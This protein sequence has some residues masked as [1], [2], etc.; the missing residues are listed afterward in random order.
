MNTLKKILKAILGL[1][2]KAAQAE[3]ASTA[4]KASAELGLAAPWQILLSEIKALFKGD[5]EIEIA[6]T[7]DYA[8][9]IRAAT[10]TKADALAQLLPPSYHFGNVTVAITVIPGNAKGESTGS[11]A[12]DAFAGNAAV[13]DI[14]D[15]SVPGGGRF[16]Y[17]LFKPEIVQF[18]NDDLSSLGLCTTFYAAIAQDTLLEPTGVFYCTAPLDP[19]DPALARL[20][21]GSPVDAFINAAPVPEAP[22]GEAAEACA[23]EAPV[24]EAPEAATPETAK[25]HSEAETQ[26]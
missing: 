21:S 12:R 11:I 13:T 23:A 5:P 1:F 3:A 2:V 19:L 20:R 24:P 8:I 17:V 14:A 22:E 10:Q 16:T 9:E 4:E 26:Q 6:V 25:P 7:G 18:Y 15:V